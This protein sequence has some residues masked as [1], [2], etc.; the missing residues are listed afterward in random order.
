[1]SNSFRQN[2]HIEQNVEERV[3]HFW[4]YKPSTGLVNG[5]KFAVMSIVCPEGTNQTSKAFGVKIFGCFATLE[6]ANKY[7]KTL[8][9]ECDAFDYYTV[10]TQAWAKLP[11]QVEK[12]DDQVFQEGELESLKNTLIK[13]R[14]ARAKMLEERIMH[15]KAE[16]KKK[17]AAAA[18][19]I[20][21][22]STP[23]VMDV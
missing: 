22:G 6:D 2:I 10:E 7:A 17:A 9:Q 18:A 11:P 12:L 5:Q 1:M 16:S 13:S 3:E 21:D 8:Q 20:T 4:E 14:I 19:A 15:D 23:T